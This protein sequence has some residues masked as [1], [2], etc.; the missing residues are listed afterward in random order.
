MIYLDPCLIACV[1]SPCWS[2]LLVHFSTFERWN[3]RVCW[4][5]E[6]SLRGHVR[7]HGKGLLPKNTTTMVSR[8]DLC[9]SNRWQCWIETVV[10][11][12]F[13][14]NNDGIKKKLLL[15]VYKMILSI[16]VLELHQAVDVFN[17]YTWAE[18][19]SEI[20]M[21]G[22]EVSSYTNRVCSRVLGFSVYGIP[23]RALWRLHVLSINSCLFWTSVSSL[24][25]VFQQN[26]VDVALGPLLLSA[27]M[28]GFVALTA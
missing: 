14:I 6:G 21:T 26:V 23:P 8:N 25:I 10:I 28:P 9:D 3:H 4:K 24:S 22:L 1:P 15:L 17:K 18:Q 2:P 11:D 16:Q 20:E 19:F 27:M 5:K 12:M 13:P 7:N